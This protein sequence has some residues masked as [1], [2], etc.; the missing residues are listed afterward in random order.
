MS[1]VLAIL[2]EPPPTAPLLSGDDVME[3]LGLEPGPAVGEALRLVA[4]ARAVGDVRD[5][6][7][8]EE[9]L[10]RYAEAQGWTNR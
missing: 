3:L 2:E 9:L 4:D 5:R 6:E 10:R 1:R 8:A 7:G